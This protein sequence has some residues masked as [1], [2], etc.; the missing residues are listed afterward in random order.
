MGY[1]AGV[2]N[3]VFPA[4]LTTIKPDLLPLGILILETERIRPMNSDIIPHNARVLVADGSK[5]L[6]L[7]NTGTN[8]N[9]ALEV[10]E[11]INAPDNASTHEQGS[12][13]PGRTASGSHRSNLGQIDLH[14]Q[15]EERFFA[16]VVKSVKAV[17]G[18]SSVTKIYIVAPPKALASIRK[19]LPDILSK[20]IVAEYDKDIVNLSID[21]LQRHLSP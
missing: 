2:A 1:A 20:K 3:T 13:R 14:R 6:L 18:D 5:A 7:R 21:Q 19:I 12:D 17:W 16:T 11:I 9:L 15:K 4:R 8:M 10:E